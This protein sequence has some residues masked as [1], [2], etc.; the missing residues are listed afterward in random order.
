MAIL[1]LDFTAL[2]E[3][4]PNRSRKEGRAFFIRI[5]HTLPEENGIA[6]ANIINDTFK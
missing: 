5:H 2:L 6:V 1:N 4:I 3:S